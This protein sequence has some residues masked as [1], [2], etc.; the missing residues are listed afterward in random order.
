MLL[1][2]WKNIHSIPPKNIFQIRKSQQDAKLNK[3]LRNA[4]KNHLTEMEMLD[5]DKSQVGDIR[6]KDEEK[7][8]ENIYV[9][10]T[11]SYFYVVTMIYIC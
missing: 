4:A 10:T 5:A 9:P 2:G 8:E 1:K 7:D 6:E 11:D 3:N